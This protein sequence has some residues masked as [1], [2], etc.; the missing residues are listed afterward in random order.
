MLLL[1]AMAEARPQ[2]A[3]V[4]PHSQSTG[5]MK[6]HLHRTLPTYTIS[7]TRDDHA[8]LNREALSLCS[9]M[10]TQS[11]FET[12]VSIIPN[13]KILNKATDTQYV[14]VVIPL[15]AGILWQSGNMEFWRIFFQTNLISCVN[16]WTVGFLLPL[17]RPSAKESPKRK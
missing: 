2:S 17:L 16:I 8:L 13:A 3:P 11:S 1:S 5:V 10:Q 12:S 9:S 14:T 4:K 15:R 7:L 6:A